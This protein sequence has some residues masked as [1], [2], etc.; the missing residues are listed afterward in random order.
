MMKS[1]E[2]DVNGEKFIMLKPNAFQLL[3]IEDMAISTSGELDLYKYY[4][5]M[6]FL[7]SSKLNIENTLK[8][9]EL[10][11][12]HTL[13]NGKV[14]SITCISKRDYFKCMPNKDSMNRVFSIEL[15]LAKAENQHIKIEELT[16]E[17][18]NVLYSMIIDLY[19]IGALSD[20]CDKVS[21]FCI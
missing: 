13:S 21:A 2:V 15:L 20:I 11:K 7:I 14:V 1:L 6:L 3:K 9:N 4:S 8:R 12:T 5:G 10:I 18:I 19:D 17:D 16:S